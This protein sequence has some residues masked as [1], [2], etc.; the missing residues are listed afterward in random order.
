MRIKNG[1]EA[2][3]I[4]KGYS[5]RTPSGN[6]SAMYQYLKSIDFVCDNENTDWNGLVNNIQS[7]LAEYEEG[8]VKEQLGEKSHNTVRCALRCFK[9]FAESKYIKK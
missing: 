5:L 4:E 1:F 9:D 6:P 2:F 8:G 3:L 7:V